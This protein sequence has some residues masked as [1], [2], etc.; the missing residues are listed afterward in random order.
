[1]P[2]DYRILLNIS[3]AGSFD[4]ELHQG[5]A[6][7][8]KMHGPWVF[9]HQ[10]PDYLGRTQSILDLAQRL[11]P[12]GIIMSES[13]EIQSIIELNIPVIVS[14]LTRLFNGVTNIIA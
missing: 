10:P 4:R 12:D 9:Y 13:P 8:S 3:H 5:I 2:K 11:K 6:M 1:M 14:P 7:Y